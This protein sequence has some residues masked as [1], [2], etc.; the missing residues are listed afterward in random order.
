MVLSAGE[1]PEKV[2]VSCAGRF[3]LSCVRYCD[4]SIFKSFDPSAD[5]TQNIRKKIEIKEVLGYTVSMFI[6]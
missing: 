2:S 1:Q 6:V 5:F 3:F 4:G